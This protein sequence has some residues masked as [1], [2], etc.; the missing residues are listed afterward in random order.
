MLKTLRDGGATL[1]VL[2]ETEYIFAFYHAGLDDRTT[3]C[4]IVLVAEGFLAIPFDTV[5]PDAGGE[6]LLL[7][8]AAIITREEMQLLVEKARLE[9]LHL[10]QLATM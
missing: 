8:K 10:E 7:D 4:V 2:M 3:N 9:F 1:G 5:I 6:Q